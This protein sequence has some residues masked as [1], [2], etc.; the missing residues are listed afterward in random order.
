MPA[1]GDD[2]PALV[3]QDSGGQVHAPLGSAPAGGVALGLAVRLAEHH[4]GGLLVAARHV[5]P[6]QHPMVAGVGDHE[7]LLPD[8]NPTRGVH[9]GHRRTRRG[10][11]Q[12][13]GRR[14][15]QP[16]CG[17]PA[18]A[19]VDGGDAV[20]T[21]PQTA[22][23]VPNGVSAHALTRTQTSPSST[24]NGSCSS[25]APGALRHSPDVAS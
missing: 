10:Q 21:R 2:Q 19:A 9:P 3:H 14:G 11:R 16:Q 17:S 15:A 25:C 24:R 4:V 8:E 18:V 6:D 1:V 22:D 12:A 23:V 13:A 5:V 20:G 7:V